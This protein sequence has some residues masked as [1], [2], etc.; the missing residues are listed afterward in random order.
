MKTDW[1]TDARFGM[2][3]HWGL[4][5]CAGGCWKGMETPWVSEWMMRKFRI[6]REEYSRLASGFKAEN[7]DAERWIRRIADA[8][9]KY[10]VITSKHHDGFAM[11]DSSW[12][13]YNIVKRT[14]FGRDPLRE[15]ADAAHKYDIRIG[16]YYSH[17]QDWN[18]P[19]AVGNTWDFPEESKTDEAFENYL[20]GKVRH[21]VRELLTGYGPVSILWFDTPH[22]ISPEQSS[23]LR[24]FVRELAP[25]CLVNSRL[26]G[27]KEWDYR[28]LADNQVPE[29]R[30]TE[31]TEGIG[32][33][34]ESWGYKPSDRNYR[35]PEEILEIMARQAACNANYL[36]NVGPDGNGDF[37]PEACNI[38]RRTGEFL[39]RNGEA[40]YGS[41]S[42]P[43]FYRCNRWG[44]ITCRDDKVYFWCFRNTGP[45]VF[46]GLRNQV[47]SAEIIGGPEIP[48]EQFSNPEYD[49]HRLT[50]QIPDLP[51]PLVIRVRCHGAIDCDPNAYSAS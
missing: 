11:F 32:T 23:S 46:Y 12:D 39:R 18:E 47:E 42:L 31:P 26:G 30:F 1:F 7:F 4:Y 17:E 48:F 8:G 37:P 10:F 20:N 6:P 24:A 34:N 36:L 28:T 22:R 33:M 3:I 21:Q 25:D 40:L 41:S 35:S 16:F 45:L 9:M 2:F 49:F 15:L 19:G 27:E 29:F 50:L 43:M 51:L 5:S 14:P 38:L 13:D 44:H